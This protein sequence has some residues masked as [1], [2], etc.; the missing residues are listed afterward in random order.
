MN[1]FGLSIPYSIHSSHFYGD[2]DSPL[3]ERMLFKFSQKK[4]EQK[5]VI[6]NYYGPIFKTN[7]LE[8]VKN[9]R[10][11]PSLKIL[12]H[13]PYNNTNANVARTI[14]VEK[15]EKM[16]SFTILI[17]KRYLF[18]NLMIQNATILLVTYLI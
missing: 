15:K 6:N 1:F 10:V 7:S 3:G 5:T 9:M 11:S 17:K 13:N 4:E 8:N 16:S 2:K 12:R 14:P 18:Q